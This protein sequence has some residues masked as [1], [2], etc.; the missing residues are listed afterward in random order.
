MKKLAVLFI[1]LSSVSVN[2]QDR[3]AKFDV[4]GDAKVSFE[5]LIAQ[6]P[7]T[8]KA[9]FSLA[10]KDNDGFLTNA[11]M[12]TAKEYLFKKCKQ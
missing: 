4:D 9:L 6:C 11:E 8:M 12:R 3:V 7:N 2:A 10:D 5:E 1:G